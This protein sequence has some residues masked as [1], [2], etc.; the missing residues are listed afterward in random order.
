M[1]AVDFFKGCKIIVEEKSYSVIK[2]KTIPENLDCFALIKDFQ[3][4]TIITE[5]DTFS[6]P[7][8]LVEEKDWKLITFKV[9]LPFEL[10]GFL[11]MV[12]KVLAEEK[13][14]IFVLSAYSTDH[15]LIN[16]NHLTKAIGRLEGLG[17]VVENK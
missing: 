4:I 7:L 1:N 8:I 6:E 9:V 13:I 3:E 14:P 15:L 2:A 5:S 17:C 16:K 10:V 12:S 11:A